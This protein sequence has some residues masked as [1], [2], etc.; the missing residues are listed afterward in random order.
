MENKI[1]KIVHPAIEPGKNILK[2]AIG[3]FMHDPNAALSLA[4][5]LKSF[6]STIRDGIFWECLETFIL[7]TYSF[8]VNQGL[9]KS[10]ARAAAIRPKT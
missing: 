4:E 2:D 6:P 7:C 5:D 9:N 8:N 10:V 1:A 3:V